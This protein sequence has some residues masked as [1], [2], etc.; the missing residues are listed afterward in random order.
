MGKLVDH[1]RRELEKAGLFNEDSD[2]GGMLGED[3]MKMV[4]VFAAQGHSGSSAQVTLAIFARVAA[5]KPLT[6]LTPNP[7]EWVE[8]KGLVDKTETM[9]WQSTRNPACFSEDGGKTYYDISATP[10]DRTPRTAEEH[11]ARADDTGSISDGY[12]TF[13]ELYDHRITLFIALCSFVATYDDIRQVW[14]S[15]LHSDGTS[16]D[17]WFVMGINKALGNQI[18]YHLPLERWTET[19][20]VPDLERAT[21]VKAKG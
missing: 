18:T 6:P 11:A 5:W 7:A 21:A 9:A 17:G 16:L 19:D 15:K 20:F 3:V 14:R 4:E 12:H 10:V 13:N 8:V 1:A 2:Y